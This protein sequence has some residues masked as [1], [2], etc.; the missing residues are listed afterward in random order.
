MGLTALSPRMIAYMA[1]QVSFPCHYLVF[2]SYVAHQTRFAFSSMEAWAVMDNDFDYS[3]FYWNIVSLFD[4]G[5]GAEILQYFNQYAPFSS[6]DFASELISSFSWVFG[7]PEGESAA[8]TTEH[9]APNKQT[10]I[11]RYKA[12][13]A[14]KRAR[15]EASTSSPLAN[16]VNP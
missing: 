14:A 16:D 4:D 5:E 10:D 11:E 1:V 13:R 2:C 3:I 12:Q 6:F 8:L 7:N 9:V 15:L